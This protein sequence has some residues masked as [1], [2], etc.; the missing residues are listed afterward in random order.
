MC[1]TREWIAGIFQRPMN[2]HERE[3]VGY[4]IGC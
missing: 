4:L 3:L 2:V 1:L